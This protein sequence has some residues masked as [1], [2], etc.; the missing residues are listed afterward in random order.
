MERPVIK[1]PSIAKAVLKIISLFVR[2]RLAGKALHVRSTSQSVKVSRA[3]ME[4]LAGTRMLTTVS[5]TPAFCH[6][7]TLASTSIFVL[8]SMVYPVSIVRWMW[9]SVQVSH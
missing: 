3:K 4:G 7:V 9:T 2:V 5:V 1:H 6:F 8:V